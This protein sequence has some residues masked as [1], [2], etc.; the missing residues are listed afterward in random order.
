MA[1]TSKP[2]NF[3]APK[4]GEFKTPRA[5]SKTEALLKL[6]SKKDG[7]TLDQIAAALSRSGAEV[8]PAYARAWVTKA[9]LA[10]YGIGVRSEETDKG[11]RL[12]AVKAE[13]KKQKAA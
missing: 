10:P 6:L 5:G 9:Y 1:K 2:I 4:A 11:V 3:P 7:A 8:S 13:Q 12:F